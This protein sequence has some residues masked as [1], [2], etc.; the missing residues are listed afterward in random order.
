MAEI[1]DIKTKTHARLLNTHG[2]VVYSR[3]ITDGLWT[4]LTR[5]SAIAQREKNKLIKNGKYYFTN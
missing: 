1:V 5:A 3:K 2:G 4:I